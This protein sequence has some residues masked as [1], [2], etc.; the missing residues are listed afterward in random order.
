MV[1]VAVPVVKIAKAYKVPPSTIYRGLKKRGVNLA[2]YTAIAGEILESEEVRKLRERIRDVK[3]KDYRHI[4]FLQGLVVSLIVESKKS[5][6][7]IAK[8]HDDIKTLK[9]A[10]DAVGNGTRSKWV[11]LGLHRENENADQELPELP[12]REMSGDEVAIMRDKQLLED[13][14]V[15]DEAFGVLDD[16]DED[17]VEEGPD[18][19]PVV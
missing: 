19:P 14:T 16:E 18:E 2:G 17:V 15:T 13:E 7:P 10:I 4:D 6:T 1:K 9:M 11:I 3:D 12:I 8:N 5:S